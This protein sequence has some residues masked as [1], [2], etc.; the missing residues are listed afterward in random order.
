MNSAGRS[1]HY[2]DALDGSDAVRVGYDGYQRQ[3][4][5]EGISFSNPDR[6]HYTVFYNDLPTM[7]KSLAGHADISTD[8]AAQM[9]SETQ[10]PIRLLSQIVADHRSD[11]SVPL[12][13]P[14]KRMAMALH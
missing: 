8:A 12:P 4:Y 9:L 6:P 5:A 11:T 1:A 10:T 14:R 13:L 3:Y 7:R 2:F